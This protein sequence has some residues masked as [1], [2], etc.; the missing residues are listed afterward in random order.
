MILGIPCMLVEH[1][2]QDKYCN[3]SR[4]VLRWIFLW[5]ALY[6]E[7][8]RISTLW[9][10]LHLPPMTL[11]VAPAM[12]VIVWLMNEYG[13]GLRNGL[14]IPTCC[15][16]YLYSQCR[17]DIW[18]TNM[19]TLQGRAKT[20]A[21]EP[22]FQTNQS[23]ATQAVPVH[24]VFL[25]F[26]HRESVVVCC[27]PAQHANRICDQRDSSDG[28]QSRNAHSTCFCL[29]LWL[30]CWCL[31]L[32]CFREIWRNY[33]AHESSLQNPSQVLQQLKFTI[34]M[35]TFSNK[36]SSGVQPFLKAR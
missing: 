10:A 30:N 16:A 31:L 21:K 32:A 12:R 4:M 5:Q 1:G 6:Q 19:P 34:G 28:P 14:S 15:I 13:Y 29:C 2:M 23:C 17:V 27:I 18:S 36:K 3:W 7:L 8:Q 25:S 22:W 35:Q 9:Y 33:M 20:L 26:Y 11:L 24:N